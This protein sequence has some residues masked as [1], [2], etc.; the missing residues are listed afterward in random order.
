VLCR[1]NHT[2][3]NRGISVMQCENHRKSRTNCTSHGLALHLSTHGFVQHNTHLFICSLAN[4]PDEIVARLCSGDWGL[5]SKASSFGPCA[6]T[7]QVRHKSSASETG[8]FLA[9]SGALPDLATPP[10]ALKIRPVRDRFPFLNSR[11]ACNTAGANSTR[12]PGPPAAP[13][14]SCGLASGCSTAESPFPACGEA[15]TRR[16]VHHGARSRI[17]HTQLRDTERPRPT[18]LTSPDPGTAEGTSRGPARSHAVRRAL[19][20]SAMLSVE[21]NSGRWRGVPRLLMMRYRY[22]CRPCGTFLRSLI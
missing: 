10:A 20:R 6:P 21:G 8:G 14:V 7:S 3:A 11:T 12:G 5:I 22:S 1:T 18:P 16:A 17:A 15:F 2:C 4:S 13:L 19:S 9:A